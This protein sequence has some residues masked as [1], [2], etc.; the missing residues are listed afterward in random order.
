MTNENNT[1]KEC[2]ITLQV[3]EL[4][5]TADYCS[6]TVGPF[7][8][9]RSVPDDENLE[10]HISDTYAILDSAH[11]KERDKVIASLAGTLDSLPK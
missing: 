11:Q 1:P 6:V 7:S 4:I 2:D 8:I 5:R 3:S 9:T 10:Q